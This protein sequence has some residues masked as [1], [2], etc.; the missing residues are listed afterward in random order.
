VSRSAV[1]Y[2]RKRTSPHAVLHRRDIHGLV[3]PGQ[4]HPGSFYLVNLI[5]ARSTWST[6]FYLVIFMGSFYLVNRVL[7]GQPH[8]VSFYLFNHVLP[9]QPRSTWSTSSWRS[10]PCRM[11][12]ARRKIRRKPT[13]RRSPKKKTRYA[14]PSLRPSDCLRLFDF[15]VVVVVVV[16][17]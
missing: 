11:T 10:S 16:K 2:S 1:G 12:T 3:L 6:T 14:C 13:R 9:G 7:P 8:P 5:M 17:S 4:P 15:I